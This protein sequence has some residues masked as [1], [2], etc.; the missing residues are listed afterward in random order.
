[1]AS[2]VTIASAVIPY[3][4]LPPVRVGPLVIAPYGALLVTGILAGLVVCVLRARSHGLSVREAFD[5]FW[6]AVMGGAVGAHLLQILAY[7]P[8]LLATRGWRA[9]VDPGAGVSSFGA[10]AGG[11]GLL[12]LRLR[13]AG[14]AAAPYLDLVVECL[15]VGWGIGR[16]G[17]ALAHDH[18][19]QLTTF[20][21]A[22][23][24]PDGPRHDLGL[25]EAAYTIFVLLPALIVTRGGLPGSETVVVAL[26]YAPARFL[27]D[28]LRA[29]DL[30]GSDPRYLGLTAAQYGCITLL[31]TAGWLA[32]RLREQPAPLDST[33]L[34]SKSGDGVG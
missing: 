31:I 30:P 26:L 5:A 29:T 7:R 3:V 24:Y 33:R 32:R 25:Y 6:W 18:P 13:A 16:V 15:V 34:D 27:L 19:G 9:L 10:F 28:F 14:K 11:V 4:D 22:V 8:E 23:A 21:L 2:I 1:M 17:C 20:P 12:L